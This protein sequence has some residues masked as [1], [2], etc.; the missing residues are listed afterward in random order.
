VTR[1]RGLSFAMSEDVGEVNDQSHQGGDS[2]RTQCGR[3]D[4]VVHLFCAFIIVFISLS[5]VF[6][7]L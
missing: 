2:E 6:R 4:V 3:D 7:F 5:M 1:N